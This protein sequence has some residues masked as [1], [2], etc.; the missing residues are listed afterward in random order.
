[1]PYL[2]KK[3]ISDAEIA[4]LCIYAILAAALANLITNVA[5][6]VKK[7]VKWHKNRKLARV[8][9]EIFYLTDSKIITNAE[10]LKNAVE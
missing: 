1:M 5:L 7:I 8:N 10:N 6:T 4:E 3:I 9:N 2:A